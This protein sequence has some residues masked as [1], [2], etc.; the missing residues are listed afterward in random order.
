MISICSGPQQQQ[1]Q[2]GSTGAY[3]THNRFN[4]LE[5]VAGGF[6]DN[7]VNI[8]N[9]SLDKSNTQLQQ[10]CNSS[11]CEGKS[12]LFHNVTVH[13]CSWLFAGLAVPVMPA[14]LVSAPLQ[15]SIAVHPLG[16]PVCTAGPAT[17]KSAVSCASGFHFIL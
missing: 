2:A 8:G 14:L 15:T 6:R 16:S 7:G 4:F 10:D 1:P 17:C 13:C 12:M 5:G 9:S 11:I 3:G